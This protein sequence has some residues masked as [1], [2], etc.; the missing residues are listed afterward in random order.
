[1]SEN[2]I[3]FIEKEPETK[4]NFYIV[5]VYMVKE[6]KE[7]FVMNF[8]RHHKKSELNLNNYKKQLIANNGDYFCIDGYIFNIFS[9]LK[10]MAEGE[11]WFKNG[12]EKAFVWNKEFNGWDFR[13]IFCI[14]DVEYEVYYRV[15]DSDLAQDIEEI[16]R[17]LYAEDYEYARILIEKHLPDEDKPRQY[18]YVCYEE[19]YNDLLIENGTFDALCIKDT[20]DKAYQYLSEQIASG[21]IDGF[22]EDE[23]TV[24]EPKENIEKDIAEHGKFSTIMFKG[25]QENDNESYAIVI[26]RKVVE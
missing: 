15:F 4:N 25:R 13:E 2:I 26:E 18:V 10:Q 6:G 14:E 1:M 20:F 17:E 24:N 3:T 16:L 19:N 23:G 5:P 21:I 7:H 8:L 9:F 12:F 22:V 11:A